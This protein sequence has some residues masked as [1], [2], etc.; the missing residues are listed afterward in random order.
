MRTPHI[1]PDSSA[2]TTWPHD[3]AARAPWLLGTG[4]R[5]LG[6]RAGGNTPGRVRLRRCLSR[7]HARVGAPTSNLS[8]PL[9]SQLHQLGPMIAQ[10]VLTGC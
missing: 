1:C 8:R 10:L 3:S 5:G 9:R 4:S 2:P 6:T 7:S